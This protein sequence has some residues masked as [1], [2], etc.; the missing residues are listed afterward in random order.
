MASVCRVVALNDHASLISTSHPNGGANQHDR[1]PTHNIFDISA[2][3]MHDP[4]LTSSATLSGAPLSN[5]H[6][7]SF[8]QTI[9]SPPGL[10]D[11]P[12]LGTHRHRHH[13]GSLHDFS[14]SAYFNSTLPALNSSMCF[15]PHPPQP[16][17]QQP[18]SLA[19]LPARAPR[20]G[21]GV[22][23]DARSRSRSW[24]PSSGPGP[25]RTQSIFCAARTSCT[26]RNLIFSGSLSPSPQ[27]SPIIIPRSS[28]SN[29]PPVD[30]NLNLTG[31]NGPN[32]VNSMDSP[33]HGKAGGWYVPAHTPSHAHLQ[34]SLLTPDSISSHM[35]FLH[36]GFANYIEGKDNTALKILEEESHA[37]L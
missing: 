28:W 18:S 13:P 1:P 35:Y 10:G 9:H 11:V 27:P 6:A 16:H 32:G 8:P 36:G 7:F 22:P 15:D 4:H 23:S 29:P 5:S 31:L 19:P 3:P 17:E 26:K 24:A 12:S 34:Y 14:T 21:T 33:L 37:T 25:I 2:P 30:L 20:P